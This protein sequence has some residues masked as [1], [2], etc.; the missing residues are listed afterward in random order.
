MVPKKASEIVK[1]QRQIETIA[2]S[3]FLRRGDRVFKTHHRLFE[4][5]FIR[6]NPGEIVPTTARL[7]IPTVILL[8]VNIH[9]P[10]EQC[11]CLL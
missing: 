6:E 9:C 2:A 5:P 3:Y 4:S 8:L 10:P 7:V 1:K 11:C